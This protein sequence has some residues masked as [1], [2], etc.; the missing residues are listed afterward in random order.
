M[1]TPQTEKTLADKLQSLP[2]PVLYLVL[3]VVTV[4]PQF[5]PVPLPNKPSAASLDL[6]NLLMTIPEDKPVLI[7]SDWTNS[8]RGESGGEFKAI[9]R[10]L[11][12]RNIKFAVYA[13]GDPQAPQVAKDRIRELNEQAKASKQ[14]VYEHWNDWVSIGYFAN[15]EGT[16]NSINNNVRTQFADKK[17]PDAAGA[18]KSVNESP[19]L[20]NVKSVADFSCLLIITASNTS[21]VAIERIT[22]TPLA[23]AVTGVMGP[24]T[25]VYYDSKQLKGLAIGLKGCYDL[26]TLM[27]EKWAGPEYV[28][29]DNGAKYYPTLHLA[30]LLLIAAVVTGN[31]GMI[32]SR[33]KGVRSGS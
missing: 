18:M 4:I 25:Q 13:V 21:N 14:K 27:A 23:M 31:I 1:A 15:P 32:M 20:K 22:K 3:I 24:E 30:L 9:V 28:N 8:T 11:M 7:E 12:R 29:M 6:F 26:E 17:G 5:I 16:L 19:V 33:K 10:I 2:K